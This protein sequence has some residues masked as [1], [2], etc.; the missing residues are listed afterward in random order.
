MDQQARLLRRIRVILVL[1]MAALVVSGLTAVPLQHELQTV[2]AALGI[3]DGASP[4]DYTG[5][6]HWI[7]LVRNGVEETWSRYPFIAYGTDWLAFAHVVIAIA[8]VGP[9]REPVR[10]AWVIDFGLIACALVVPMA[11]V[12]GL[13]RGI[14][15]YWRLID[16][17]FGVLGFL[18]LWLCRGYVKELEKGR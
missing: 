6:R 3:P 10:N 14:P 16:C 11:L 17:S 13:I 4:S 7:A 15:L 5:V 9:S 8:F 2:A 18:P 12:F 1:F